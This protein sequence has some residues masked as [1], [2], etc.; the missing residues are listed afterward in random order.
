[1]VGFAP[2][3]GPV[4]GSPCPLRGACVAVALGGVCH[5]L[6]ARAMSGGLEIRVLEGANAR[7]D[8][9]SGCVSFAGVHC[10]GF[11]D[12]DCSWDLSLGQ[13]TGEEES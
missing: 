1:M 2:G 11:V 6:C 7:S 3:L 5:G 4:T 10:T 13:R 8:T 9:G 12:G